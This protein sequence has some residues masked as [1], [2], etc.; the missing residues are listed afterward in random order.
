MADAHHDAGPRPRPASPDASPA[1][2]ITP[3][4]PSYDDA[5]RLWN[6]VHDRRPAVIVRPTTADEVATAIR[7]AREQDLELAVRSGGHSRPAGIDGADGGL[8]V[9]LSAMRGVDGRPGGAHRAGERRRA[10]RRARRRGAGARP[11]LPGRRRRSH[12]RRRADAR[13]RRRPAPAALRAHDRQ[14]RAVELVTAD[15]RLV[16]AS[17]TE[18]PDLF[19][20]MR[21]A[22]WNFGIVTAFEFGLHPFGPDLHRGV[23]DLPGSRRSTRSGTSSRDYARQRARRGRR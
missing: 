3:E 4:D 18:E 2:I 12:R 10:P 11:R 22:G 15:G 23:R 19:W 6:A 21:G 8:V 5:R 7:F 1:T 13:R 9:D 17:E 14:P 20:G 16:R